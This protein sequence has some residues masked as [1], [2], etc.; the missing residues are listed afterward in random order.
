MW[1]SNPH[2][3]LT[4]TRADAAGL[5]APLAPAMPLENTAANADLAKPPRFDLGDVVLVES[6]LEREDS[7]GLGP[8]ELLGPAPLR[9][10]PPSYPETRVRGFELLPPFRVGASPR[11]SL[12]PHQACG[13]VSC[14]LASDGPEDPWGLS[15]RTMEMKEQACRVTGTGCPGNLGT[16]DLEAAAKEVAATAVE[17]LSYVGIA[18]GVSSSLFGYDFVR[19]EEVKGPLA[20]VL[21]GVSVIPGI[22]AT[23]RRI[24]D[25]PGIDAVRRNAARAVDDTTH[26]AKA[27]ARGNQMAFSEKAEAIVSESTGVA[28]NTRGPGQQTIPG[29]GRGGV[30]VPDLRLR[31]AGGSFRLRGSIVEVKAS[32]TGKSFGDLSARSRDQIRDAVTYARRLQERANLVK[33]PVVKETLLS[34]HVEVFSDLKAPTSGEFADLM[35][36]GILRWKAIPR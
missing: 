30:R 8:L 32:A 7:F 21:A 25:I 20:R 12:W 16:V 23:I 3:A 10:P 36:E 35:E 1:K 14:A 34:A 33:D 2:A 13:P 5:L 6:G 24:D 9:G 4:A 26:A 19:N 31:G 28:R 15:E 17:E 18:N 11:L 22:P 29:T 27:T